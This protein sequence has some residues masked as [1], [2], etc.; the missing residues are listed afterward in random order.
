MTDD[1]LIGNE[2]YPMIRRLGMH[3]DW[4]QKLSQP[5]LFGYENYQKIRST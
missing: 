2:H 4:L 3:S 5:T 1:A